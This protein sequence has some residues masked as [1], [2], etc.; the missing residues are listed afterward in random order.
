M[1][2][3]NSQEIGHFDRLAATWWDTKGEMGPLHTLNTPRVRFIEQASGGLAGKR[4]VDVGC[5]G[6][7]LTEALA[8]KGARALGIDLAEAALDVARQ[9]A[10]KS[11]LEIEY[12]SSAAEALAVEQAGAFD[13]VCCLEMLEHVPDPSSVVRACAQLVKPGGDVVFSTINRNPKSFALAI[14]GAEYVMSL[15]PRGTHDYAKFIRPSELT[16]WCREAG[17][18][19]VSLRG[20]RYNPFLKSASLSDDLDVN[21]LLHCRRAA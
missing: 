19:A 8:A 1:S 12:R 6:G 7:I 20:L 18:D 14:V 11:G 10:V 16:Q 2:N 9:H 3:V 15:V 17:L 13:L 21:Y 5:G 4:A